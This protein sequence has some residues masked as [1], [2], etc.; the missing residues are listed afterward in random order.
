MLFFSIKKPD[1][2][3]CVFK[4]S[5]KADGEEGS[6]TSPLALLRDQLPL[7]SL[8]GHIVATIPPSGCYKNC[9]FKG[10]A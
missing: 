10:R 4:A 1:V 9:D 6:R 8:D 5:C 2:C 7:A 3:V